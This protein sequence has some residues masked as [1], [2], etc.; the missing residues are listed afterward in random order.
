H[1]EGAHSH[2]GEGHE[3]RAAASRSKRRDERSTSLSRALAAVRCADLEVS[4][5]GR[6]RPQ[7]AAM[8]FH[9]NGGTNAFNPSSPPVV[10]SSTADGV[11]G[12]S[13]VHTLTG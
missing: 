6:S 12:P 11:C 7:S 5:G 13:N 1:G 8:N 3:E 2:R 9:A 10:P 4:V